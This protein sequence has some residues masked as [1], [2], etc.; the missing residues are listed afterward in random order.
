MTEQIG[1]LV[2]A[3][4]A[5]QPAIEIFDPP[6]CYRRPTSKVD[7]YLLREREGLPHPLTLVGLSEELDQANMI[8]EPPVLMKP[9]HGTQGM[10]VK[11]LKTDV[12]L[13]N[14]LRKVRFER[15]EIGPVDENYGVH[16]QRH[17]DFD[18]E[19]RIFVIGG[20]AIGIAERV[21]EAGWSTGRQSSLPAADFRGC[22]EDPA[23]SALAERAAIVHGF[24]FAGVD[25]VRKGEELFLLECNRNPQFSKFEKA[26]ELDV[27]SMMVDFMIRKTS[28]SPI[29]EV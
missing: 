2:E 17:V 24:S 20:K 1:D 21:R 29:G 11:L 5:F 26:V 15:S 14:E 19:Y 27:A 16:L 12:A 6:G 3:L 18:Q 28:G 10:G 8:L 7:S 25:V 23:A 9:T 22:S 4:D 13:A